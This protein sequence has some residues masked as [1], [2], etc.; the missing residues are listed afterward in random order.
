MRI[1]DW[2]SDVCSSDLLEE[3]AAD[4]AIGSYP[5][6][7]ANVK[8][9]TLFREDYVCILP[10]V[11][12]PDGILSL[13][14]FKSLDHIVVDGRHY[15]HGHQEAERLILETV[16]QRRVRMVSERLEEH[17]SELQSLMRISYA[18]LRLKK[19]KKYTPKITHQN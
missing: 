17:T 13:S 14:D 12:A 5:S 2:S 18:G 7:Y 19:K 11:L 4:V 1:S 3:G 9:Q 8:E 15:S 6:L 16:D 10:K